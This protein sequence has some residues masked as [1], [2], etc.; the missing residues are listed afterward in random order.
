MAGV[1]LIM[2][3]PRGGEPSSARLDRVQNRNG[4]ELQVVEHE[5]EPTTR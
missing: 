4:I 5:R 3:A 2:Y 1:G